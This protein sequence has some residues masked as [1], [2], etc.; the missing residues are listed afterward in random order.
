MSGDRSVWGKLGEGEKYSFARGF[1]RAGIV[2]CP[3]NADA[4]FATS[5]GPMNFLFLG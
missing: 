3:V 4:A 1:L 2:M 5:V